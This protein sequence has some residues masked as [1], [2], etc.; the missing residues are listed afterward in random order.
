[1]LCKT[2][3]RQLKTP[4]VCDL[5]ENG[6]TLPN[7][8]VVARADTVKYVGGVDESVELIAVEDFDLWLRLA[9]KTER[10]KFVDEK[11]GG[12]CVGKENISKR[13]E[14][15][16]CGIKRVYEKHMKERDSKTRKNALA[17]MSYFL[18][19]YFFSMGECSKSRSYYFRAIS[20]NKLGLKT[21]AIIRLCETFVKRGPAWF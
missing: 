4:V 3:L 16:I 18:G 17:A 20:S 9:T 19:H 8:S 13:S 5:L 7:S 10:F 15:Q 11:L 6:N 1:M 21:K 2:R 12:Y 14:A